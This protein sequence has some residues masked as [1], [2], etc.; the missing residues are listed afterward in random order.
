MVVNYLLNLAVIGLPAILLGSAESRAVSLDLVFLTLLGQ[1]ADKIG[2]FLA[3][4][5]SIPINAALDKFI[6]SDVPGLGAPAFMY[7]IL[8]SNLICSAIAVG[9]L[10]LWFLRKRW[11][12]ARPLS[13]KIA[14][15]AAVLTNPA[16]SL[17]LPWWK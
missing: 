4:F 8:A 14:L 1:V 13:C 16:W 11:S 6:H 5:L 2:A 17:L 7:A 3:F 10:A 15:A 12:I 9:L